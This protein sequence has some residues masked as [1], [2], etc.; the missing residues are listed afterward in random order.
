MLLSLSMVLIQLLLFKKYHH[1]TDE[2]S[3][4]I[5]RFSGLW[6]QVLCCTACRSK[7]IVSIHP[8]LITKLLFQ[9]ICK[10]CTP[11]ISHVSFCE[12]K[13]RPLPYLY[14]FRIWWSIMFYTLTHQESIELTNII[15]VLPQVSP[16]CSGFCQLAMLQTTLP[17]HSV[18][19]TLCKAFSFSYCIFFASK[20]S[21]RLGCGL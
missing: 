3:Q 17:Y 19:L 5:R 9:Y 13:A 21:V 14:R 20:M 8:N 11:N 1:L 12:F 15:C 6:S 18:C 16:G 7:S 4:N 10:Q 2:I